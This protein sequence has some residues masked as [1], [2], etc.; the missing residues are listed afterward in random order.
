MTKSENHKVDDRFIY[1]RGKPWSDNEQIK[2]RVLLCIRKLGYL[3]NIRIPPWLFDVV[4]LALSYL[5]FA[6]KE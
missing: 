3:S 1:L 6:N 5:I 2:G 4:I